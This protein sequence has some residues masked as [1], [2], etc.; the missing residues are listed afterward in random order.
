MAEP[1]DAV[2]YAS[3]IVD[4]VDEEEATEALARLQRPLLRAIGTGGPQV[5]AFR[6]EEVDGVTVHSVRVSADA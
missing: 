2:P 1:T 4:G 3:L 5:P 6:S